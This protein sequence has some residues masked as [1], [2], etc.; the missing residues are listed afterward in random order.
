[1]I[2]FVTG[3]D[4][5]IGKTVATGLLAAW[6]MR[7]GRRT[8][9]QKL[10][11]TGCDRQSEDIAQHRRLMGT[12]M[13]AD[14][15]QQLTCPA[16]F[17]FPASPH[18]AAALAGASL[19]VAALVASTQQLAR[20][21]DVVLVEGA[22]GLMVPLSR[23]ILMI[24]VVAQQKWPVVLVTAPRLG[25]INHS[26]L[27]LDALAARNIQLAAILYNLYFSAAPEIVAD[28]RQL[29][30]QAA[31]ERHWKA[32]VLDLPA[33]TTDTTQWHDPQLQQLLAH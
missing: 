5:G 3:I 22:G 11:Q 23:G 20:R 27:S 29:L 15:Q 14:D 32:P 26:L 6:F 18:L 16:I 17:P 4:T 28:T 12:G 30:Q 24:D 33:A 9:T 10:V 25:S 19:N 8:I 13:L 31:R 2:L 7:Q 1:M 21:Y